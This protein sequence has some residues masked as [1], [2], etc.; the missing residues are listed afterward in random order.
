MNDQQIQ[1]SLYG[2]LAQLMQAPQG[3]GNALQKRF[4][5]FTFGPG[6]PQVYAEQ[7]AKAGLRF[8]PET[9]LSPHVLVE[10]TRTSLTLDPPLDGI[11]VSLSAQGATQTLR[12]YFQDAAFIRR[13][14]S[15]VTAMRLLANGQ[16][17]Q[18][19]QNSI[20]PRDYIYVQLRRD[21]S[22][23]TFIS[24]PAPL[25]EISGTGAHAYFWNLVPVVERS[26][27]LLMDLSLIPP[28]NQPFS[29]PPFVDWVGL[30]SISLHTERFE[31]FSV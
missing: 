1:E 10:Y 28:G 6:Y 25:S 11:P 3:P 14:A 13:M 27:S 19:F 16:P 17:D 31:P 22:G 24:D 12:F 4:Q 2:A 21:G 7:A 9:K 30:V 5:A 20:D 18:L 29:A 15:T 8:G 26:G 23:D